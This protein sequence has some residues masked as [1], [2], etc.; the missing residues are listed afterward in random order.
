MT[1]ARSNA[2]AHAH[3]I[4]A[5]IETLTG[6]RPTIVYDDM[7]RYKGVSIVDGERTITSAVGRSWTDVAQKLRA[8]RL[9]LRF[10][11]DNS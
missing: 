9:A 11:L 6:R 2:K 7:P 1:E 3:R 10:V 8:A 5:L 4:C